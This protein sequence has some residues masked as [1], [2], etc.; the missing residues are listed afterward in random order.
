MAPASEKLARFS[1]LNASGLLRSIPPMSSVNVQC[2]FCSLP[3][4][5]IDEAR[6]WLG[7]AIGEGGSEIELRAMDDPDLEPLWKGIGQVGPS[8]EL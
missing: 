4:E 7:K 8:S 6:M 2:P 1:I 3:K 5:R